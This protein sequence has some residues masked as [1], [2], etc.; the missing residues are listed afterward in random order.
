MR[1]A[2]D[3]VVA[4]NS[5]MVLNAY[6][7]PN[8]AYVSKIRYYKSTDGKKLLADIIPFSAN[9]PYGTL[10][11]DK[12][13]TYTIINN[14]YTKAGVNTFEYID[15]SGNTMSLPIADLHIIK[16]LRVNLVSKPETVNNSTSVQV[17]LRNR[18]VNL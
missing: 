5:E 6:F 10:L 18:K 11:T 14:F 7:S 13:R 16:G 17:S 8:D 1:G 9:P 2:T 15:A 4:S 12:M 3:V